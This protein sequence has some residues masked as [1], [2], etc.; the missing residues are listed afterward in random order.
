MSLFNLR[1]PFFRPLWRRIAVVAVCAGWGFFELSMGNAF[2]VVLFWGL[3]GV[4]AYEFFVI[5]DEANYR[6][7]DET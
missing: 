5:Y 7:E 1:H 2:W 4:C 6:D 3:A